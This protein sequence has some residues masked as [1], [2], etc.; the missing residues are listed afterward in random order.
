MACDSAALHT[1]GK[2]SPSNDCDGL[3]LDQDLTI[4]RSKE[5]PLTHSESRE[6]WGEVDRIASCNG[7]GVRRL[8]ALG[9]AKVTLLTDGHDWTPESINTR[10][11]GSR[12]GSN[13]GMI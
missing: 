4:A 9:G 3:G 1:T 2:E 8:R 7:R 11:R 12:A 13:L 10:V 5:D 6:R